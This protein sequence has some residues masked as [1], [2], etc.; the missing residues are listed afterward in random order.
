MAT[1]PRGIKRSPARLLLERA[2]AEREAAQRRLAEAQS[3]V[4]EARSRQY[5]AVRRA[6]ALLEEEREAR[7][8]VVAL[9]AGGDVDELV[10][11]AAEIDAA[12]RQSRAWRRA[13]K[14]AEH[15]VIAREAALDRARADV[16]EAARA[17]IEE[18]VDVEKLVAECASAREAVVHKQH[19]LASIGAL[20]PDSAKRRA[21]DDFLAEQW[22]VL[23][24]DHPAGA[25][26]VDAFE[27]LRSNGERHR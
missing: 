8:D 18:S 11:P 23:Q 20:L 9:I 4:S 3:A 19:E 15:E 14:A 25:P 2:I 7:E 12:E 21:I 16:D 26:Y 27:A 13:R 24:E 6:E 22:L 5:A 17:V 1:N 10:R